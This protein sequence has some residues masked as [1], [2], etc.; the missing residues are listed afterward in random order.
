M[1][2]IICLIDGTWLSAFSRRP[3]GAY[4]NIFKLNL[5]L[6]NEDANGNPQ[7]TFY[8]PG[9]GSRAGSLG[10]FAGGMG[11]GLADMVEEAY[12]NICTN[13]AGPEDRIYL[14]GFSRGAVVARFVAGLI[15]KHGLFYPEHV[16]RFRS[17]LQDVIAR[18]KPNLLDKV[19]GHGTWTHRAKRPSDRITRKDVP[20]EFVGVFD[21]VYGRT[22]LSDR[23]IKALVT[24]DLS[25]P[26]KVQHAMQVL[27]LDERRNPYA[28]QVWSGFEGKVGTR[29]IEQIWIPGIH[30]DVGGIFEDDFLGN[31]A[32]FTMMDRTMR[33]TPLCFKPIDTVMDDT[34][35][36]KAL[37]PEKPA[38]IVING[39]S[40]WRDR[41][42][43]ARGSA[44][45]PGQTSTI[46]S[47]S[48]VVD[49]LKKRGC[50]KFMGRRALELPPGSYDL[51]ADYHG[52][53]MAHAVDQKRLGTEGLVI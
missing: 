41:F 11:R 5:L 24:S 31:M 18:R 39:Y 2:H 23:Y 28:P 17:Y 53:H 16:D 3:T 15:S 12:I 38:G 46:Q 4:S 1:K 21:T 8:V 42:L 34:A 6:E 48:S 26:A 14:F 49:F 27:A 13:Y 32:L 29:T 44:R 25:V 51:L 47:L 43:S 40:T 35:I 45:K 33:R 52:L 36:L 10:H 37:A 20:V 7:V 22:F 30:G 9:M 19:T 50:T